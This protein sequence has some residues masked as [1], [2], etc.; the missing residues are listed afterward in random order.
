MNHEKIFDEPSVS[1]K[2]VKH[3][4]RDLPGTLFHHARPAYAQRGVYPSTGFVA[5]NTSNGYRS[6]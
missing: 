3:L 5:K 2:I 1:P 6:K 4:P